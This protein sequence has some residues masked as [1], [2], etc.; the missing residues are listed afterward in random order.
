[1]VNG[2]NNFLVNV[3]PDLVKTINDPETTKGVDNFQYRNSSSIF[4]KRVDREEIINIVRKCKS[5]SSVDYN[6]IDMIIIKNVIEEIVEPLTYIFNLSF[7]SGKFPNKMKI[8]K[9]IPVYKN[10]DR[11]YFTNYRLVSILPQFSKVLEKLYTKRLDNFIETHNLLVEN[12]YGFQTNRSTSLALMELMEEITN[13]IDRKK[14]S[15]IFYRL[16]ESI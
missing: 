12:Q 15:K 10:G 6:N 2:F 3:G 16:K 9:I 1:M 14:C 13:R 4:L 7:Q 5:K 8:A 11:Y